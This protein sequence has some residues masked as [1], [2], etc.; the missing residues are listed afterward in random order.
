MVNER[1]GE[2]H[3]NEIMLAKEWFSNPSWWFGATSEIDAYIRKYMHL[4]D[5]PHLLT[6]IEQI[7]LYDQFVRH[8]FRNQPAAHVIEYFRQ[9][10]SN[11]E[12]DLNMLDNDSFC[13]ALMPRRH[14]G[15]PRQIYEAMR[16]CWQRDDAPILR[17]FLRASYERCPMVGVCPESA[18]IVLSLS[19]GVDSMV[20]SVLFEKKIAAA[21]HINYGNRPTSDDEARFVSTWC[22]QRNIPCYIRKIAEIQREPCMQRGLRDVYETYTRRVRYFC[23]KEFGNALI[24]LG[25][26]KDDRLENIFTNIASRSKYENLDGMEEY[27]EQDGIHF[28]RPLLKMTKKEI[29]QYAERHAIPHLPCSTPTWSQRGKIRAKIVPV[30]EEWHPGFSESLHTLSQ[31]TRDLT[32]F[33]K[34]QV[35]EL[36]AN[37][38]ITSDYIE[39]KLITLPEALFFWRFLFTR[40]NIKISTKSIQNMLERKT[41]AVLNKLWLMTHEN[42]IL[43]FKKI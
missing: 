27:S 5:T 7:L 30:V 41:K 24:I 20:C 15:D 32:V 31:T 39:L 1:V 4:L 2:L 38:L 14:S 10:A 12:I 17:K 26:N 16:L 8:F 19:G 42:G 9:K 25:H 21:I 43:I 6:P 23:Y 18:P 29:F 36:V 3:G 28:W 34:H 40:L 33:V 22:A 35:D 37:S 11:V 13:F